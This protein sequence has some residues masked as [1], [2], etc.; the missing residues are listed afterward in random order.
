MC[1]DVCM[2][3]CQQAEPAACYVAVANYIAM[4]SAELTVH[5]GELLEM[6]SNDAAVGSSRSSVQ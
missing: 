6:F 1:V 2:Q 3:M 5:K 4:S